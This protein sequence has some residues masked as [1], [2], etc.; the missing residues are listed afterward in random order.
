MSTHKLSKD[1]RLPNFFTKTNVDFISKMVTYTISKSYS[2]RKVVIPDDVIVNY[3]TIVHDD[4]IESIPEMNQRVIADLVRSFL[5]FASEQERANMWAESRWDALTHTSNLG[6][7]KFETPRMKGD[8]YV[9]KSLE[10]KFLF[11]FTF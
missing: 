10:R 7:K 3:C 9:G 6:I 4:R 2:G 11:Q 1:S 8:R 5:D